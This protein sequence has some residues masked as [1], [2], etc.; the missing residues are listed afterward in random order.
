[1]VWIEAGFWQSSVTFWTKC[2][3]DGAEGRPNWVSSFLEP[4][5]DVKIASEGLSN[6]VE[7]VS[8]KN[9]VLKFTLD[10]ECVFSDTFQGITFRR[11]GICPSA[12]LPFPPVRFSIYW[13]W[14]LEISTKSINFFLR[15]KE[16]AKQDTKSFHFLLYVMFVIG[17]YTNYVKIE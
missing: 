4:S 3:Q 11:C 9:A 7:F 15:N 5:C 6:Y 2:V 16:F 8:Y 13:Y 10:M 14:N 12:I 1:M 17:I